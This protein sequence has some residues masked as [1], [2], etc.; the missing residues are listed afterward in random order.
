MW[1]SEEDFMG[2]RCSGLLGWSLGSSARYLIEIRPGVKSGL[3]KGILL[4]L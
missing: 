2:S 1:S 3:K 4:D